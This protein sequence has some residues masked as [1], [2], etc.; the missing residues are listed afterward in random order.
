MV[1]LSEIKRGLQSSTLKH[2]KVSADQAVVAGLVC[3]T[4]AAGS[5]LMC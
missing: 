3:C 5:V 2:R 4:Y 1:E